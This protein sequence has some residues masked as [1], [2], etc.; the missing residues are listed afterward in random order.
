MCA[1]KTIVKRHGFSNFLCCNGVR[2]RKE[3]LAEMYVILSSGFSVMGF[4]CMGVESNVKCT[5]ETELVG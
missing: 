1:G 2:C 3:C 4:Y 5:I